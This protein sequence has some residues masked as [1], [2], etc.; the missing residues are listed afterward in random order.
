MGLSKSQKLSIVKE[1]MNIEPLITSMK[2]NPKGSHSEI[3]DEISKS[4]LAE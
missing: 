4:I 2:P 3:A 1:M